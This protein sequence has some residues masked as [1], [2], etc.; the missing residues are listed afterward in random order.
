MDFNKINFYYFPV[1]GQELQGLLDVALPV[2]LLP[3]CLAGRET[4]LLPLS[5]PSPL[6]RC[7]WPAGCLE[8]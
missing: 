5:V 8:A 1:H 2:Q 7:S 4:V 3:P 6:P